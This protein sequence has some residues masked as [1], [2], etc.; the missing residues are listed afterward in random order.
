L[1]LLAQA[2]KYIQAKVLKQQALLLAC[3][4]GVDSMV[5]L[6]LLVKAG[7]K[8]AI[9]HCNFKLRPQASADAHFVEQKA[10]KLGLVF[11][12]KECDTQAYAQKNGLS[13]QMAARELRYTFFSHLK[14]K[15]NYTHLLTAHHLDDSIETL[16][17]NLSRGTG[18]S[19][20]TG[21][22]DTRQQI[23][24]PLNKQ[25]KRE[26]VDYARAQNIAWQEDASNLSTRYAR[27][28]VRHKVIPAWRESKKGF[29][30]ALGQSL[31]H[32]KEQEQAL[33]ALLAEKLEKHVEQD[34]HYEKL[35]WQGKPF[36]P[37][38]LHFWLKDLPTVD[39]AALKR[40]QKND[41]HLDFSTNHF[42]LFYSRGY[43]WLNKNPQPQK[44]DPIYIG[45]DQKELTQPIALKIKLLQPTEANYKY[46]PNKAYLD[47]AKLSF[48]LELRL[49]R[50]GDK[51]RPLG[52]KGTKKVSDFLTDQKLSR[53]AKKNQWVL[54]SGKQIAWVV[55][56]QIDHDYRITDYTKTIYFAQLF[57]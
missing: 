53:V 46:G 28:Y 43:F 37:A 29:N 39:Y 55:G 4:G 10:K 50:A 48:P 15:Y 34:G 24:R 31:Q 22:T 20:L 51:F 11:H 44:P 42:E 12:L 21:I 45:R 23:I 19:G 56:L 27:N 32:L 33:H 6:D 9:A 36:F 26:I 13:I 40:V 1:P 17:L 5:L 2:K 35:A 38:L 41:Q 3:S 7:H 18:I 54:C 16:M 30:K 57:N 25:T 49:W 52:M 8:P 14:I 47:L